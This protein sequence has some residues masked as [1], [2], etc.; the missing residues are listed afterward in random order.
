MHLQILTAAPGLPVE[1]A[2]Q[3]AEL[4]AP[5][6]AEIRVTGILNSVRGSGFQIEQGFLVTAKHVLEPF[7]ITETEISPFTSIQVTPLTGGSGF[8]VPIERVVTNYD[9][10]L[11]GYSSRLQDL[12]LGKADDMSEGDPVVVLAAPGTIEEPLTPYAGLG[13]I[14]AM[15]TTTPATFRYTVPI[16][17]GSSGGAVLN[18]DGQV[19]GINLIRQVYEGG[20]V[21]GIGLKAE[22]IQAA[23]E[24]RVYTAPPEVYKVTEY[25]APIAIGVGAGLLV[26]ALARR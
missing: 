16:E 8:V 15:T 26:V 2:K 7:L 12:A 13:Q 20:Q 5:A 25:I 14:A 18:L 3:I 19:V 9:L 17:P 24:G 6:C 4:A 10:V 1:R 23:I 21:Y 11:L 22:A